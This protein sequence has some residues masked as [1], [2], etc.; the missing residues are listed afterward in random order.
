MP[1]AILA[2]HPV[3]WRTIGHGPRPVLALH[4][5]LAHGGA[6]G[7][8]GTALADAVT[9]TA[10][11]LPAHGRSGDWD[12]RTPM[13]R[14]ATDVAGAMAQQV[15]GGAPVDVIG[16]SFGG[17][18]ALRLALERPELVR[19]LVL[20]EPVFFAAARLAGSAAFT[21]FA[22]LQAPFSQAL[23][24]GDTDGAARWFHRM[25]GMGEELE[26]LPEPQRRYII[27]RIHVIPSVNDV[28]FDDRPGLLTPGRLEGL[29][30]PVLLIE[31][32]QSPPVIAAIMAALHTRLPQSRRLAVPGATHMVPITHAEVIAPAVR[33]HLGLQ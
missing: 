9:L 33:A 18:V 22:A 32:Q 31:G 11:D 26:V 24:E 10:P 3:H 25:W 21:E 20:V 8:L 2:G 13:H 16:H 19:S 15:C 28:L 12:R 7:P 5:S 1:D 30:I 23:A 27:D 6:W 29:P 4:C 17:T 14:L